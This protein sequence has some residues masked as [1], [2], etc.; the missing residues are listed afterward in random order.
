MRSQLQLQVG[1]KVAEQEEPGLVGC[2]VS[3]SI[4]ERGIL[5][6]RLEVGPAFRGWPKEASTPRQ[7]AGTSRGPELPKGPWNDSE[8]KT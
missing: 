1:L 5:E 6:Q 4:A 7:E 2:G 3:A 8:A